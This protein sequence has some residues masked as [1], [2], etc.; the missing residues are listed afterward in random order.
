[1][2]K[3]FFYFKKWNL[4]NEWLVYKGIWL[5]V[6]QNVYPMLDCKYSFHIY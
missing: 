2:I 5:Y 6:L 1:M 4:A 3:F